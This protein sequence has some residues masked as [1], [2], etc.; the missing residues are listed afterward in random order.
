MSPAAVYLVL[1][2]LGDF[3]IIA[4]IAWWI[5]SRKRIASEVV[6]RAEDH[7]RQLRS[8]AERDGESVKKEAQLEAREN[9]HALLADAERKARERQQEIVGLE[10]ALADKTRA[11][12]DRISA[13]DALDRDLRKRD[14]AVADLQRRAEAAALR[15]EQIVADRQR[16]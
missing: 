9:A 5:A 3:V 8:Q 12:A 4:A 7:A 14:A 1:T 6:G 11:L 16:E 13:A 10:Q 15:S 2:A